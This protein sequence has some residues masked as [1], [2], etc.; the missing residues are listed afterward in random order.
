MNQK[1]LLITTK[2]EYLL[3]SS[4]LDIIYI[5]PFVFTGLL[6]VLLS[7]YYQQEIITNPLKVPVL[8]IN[9]LESTV[10]SGSILVR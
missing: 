1:K 7:Y 10:A 9:P 8:C 2:N 6:G 3:N 4:D 5:N